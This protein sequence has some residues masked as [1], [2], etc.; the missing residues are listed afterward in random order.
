MVE[1]ALNGK[2]E[3]V[4]Y[5]YD[6]LFH[7]NVP[8]TCP[9]IPNKILNPVNMWIDKEDYELTANRLAN[10]FSAAFDEAYG[11]KNINES[12]RTMISI[13]RKAAKTPIEQKYEDF[14]YP[15]IT[16]EFEI[17]F[18]VLV[19]LRVQEE[20]KYLYD[21]PNYSK[22]IYRLTTAREFFFDVFRA[23]SYLGSFFRTVREHV[24]NLMSI[25]KLM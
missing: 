8:K 23:R 5:I 19:N 18:N 7:L 2:L 25:T 3:E 13:I 9:G 6:E 1:A 12:V 14:K 10:K 20:F 4:E 15:E 11:Y 17:P 24:A 22:F 16:E 21:D